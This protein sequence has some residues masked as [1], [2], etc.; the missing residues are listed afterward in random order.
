MKEL[1]VGCLLPTPNTTSSDFK[2]S[3]IVLAGDSMLVEAKTQ[4][5]FRVV[6]SC[7]ATAAIYLIMSH[8]IASLSPLVAMKEE[9]ESGYLLPSPIRPTV[10]VQFYKQYARCFHACGDDNALPFLGN[11]SVLKLST[12]STLIAKAII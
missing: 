5:I 7:F 8:P 12:L 9:L 6:S 4:F 1:D 11:S 10:A 3:C 2:S